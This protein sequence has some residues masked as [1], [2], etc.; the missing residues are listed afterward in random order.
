M[1]DSTTLFEECY[2]RRLEDRMLDLKIKISLL[3]TTF[4]MVSFSGIDD[5]VC[6]NLTNQIKYSRYKR[7]HLV[8]KTI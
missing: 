5:L 2:F 8:C 3:S 6:T 1:L 4:N 7:Y